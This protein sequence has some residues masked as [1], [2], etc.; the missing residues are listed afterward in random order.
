[1][2]TKDQRVRVYS[3]ATFEGA[4]LRELCTVHKGAVTC[5]DLSANGGFMLTGGEDNLLKIWDYD[6]QKSV[7]YFFQAFIGHTYPL[8]DAIF[9]P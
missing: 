5:T 1:M 4:Y 2:V 7:P 8:V 3:L 6:A 9:N